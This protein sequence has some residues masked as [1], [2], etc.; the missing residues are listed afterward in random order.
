MPAASWS[1]KRSVWRAPDTAAVRAS[2]RRAVPMIKLALGPDGA[3]LVQKSLAP[4]IVVPCRPPDRYDELTEYSSRDQPWRHQLGAIHFLE[5]AHA[6]LGAGL[7]D[8]GMGTGKTRVVLEYLSRLP[9]GKR[10]ALVVAPKSVVPAWQEQAER[11]VSSRL[12]VVGIRR[13]K[14]ETRCRMAVEAIANDAVA[15]IGWAALQVMQPAERKLLRAALDGRTV[16]ADEVHFA[17]GASSK[18]SQALSDISELAAMRIGAS[19][20]PLAHSPLDAYGVFRFLD[21]GVF[22]TSKWRF[23][24][25]YAN[26]VQLGGTKVKVTR[27]YKNLDIL[28][29]RMSPYT[30]TVGREVL[31]LPL[32]TDTDSMVDLPPSALR[33]YV[34]MKKQCIA[35]L[36]SG[37]LMAANALSKLLRLQ[38]IT[39]G[40]LPRADDKEGFE[41]IHTE[42]QTALEELF[43]SSDGHEPWVAFGQFRHD[44]VQTRAAAEAVGR[45]CFELNGSANELDE[46]RVSAKAG[47]GPVLAVQYQAGGTGVDLTAAHLCVFVSPTYSLSNYEQARARVSRPPQQLPVSFY[48][49]V[50]QGTT[51]EDV[52][53]ALKRRASVLDSIRAALIEERAA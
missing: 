30:Y 18:R 52:R 33:I 32:E 43:E 26:K 10:G 42:K 28:A 15:V 23:E 41:I 47:Q 13:G 27:G 38:Q 46:W 19:G 6:D 11:F 9:H 25:R 35:E 5:W 16:I 1:K 51:D 48:H 21:P 4:S 39:S 45:P 3:M 17:K 29:Q 34:Q 36:Q 8:M 50:A 44:A 53:K 2:I 7:L 49:I 14:V 37:T 24:D 40:V 31:D 22:G 20:T 12:R